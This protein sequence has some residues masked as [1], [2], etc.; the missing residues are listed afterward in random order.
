MFKISE[1][2]RLSGTSTRMLRHYE[3]WQLLIPNYIDEKTK[4]RFY[5]AQQLQTVNK[6]KKLQSLGFSLAL[7]KEIFAARDEQEIE[8]YLS[9]RKQEISKELEAIQLQQTSLN[10]VQEVIGTNAT[11][12]DYHVVLKEIPERDVM[13][14]RETIPDA[15]YEGELWRELY[16]EVQEQNVRFADPMLGISIYHDSEYQEESIDLEIQSSITGSYQETERVKY[17]VAPAL[18]V[19]SVTF[20]GPYEQMPNVMEI[21]AQWMENN[22]YRING[23]MLNINHVSPAQEENPDHWVTEACLVVAKEE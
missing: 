13:S 12:L 3:K 18:Q 20:H 1:F 11:I 6:I 4:Y 9:L 5:S 14:I 16:T 23:P 22:D 2:S 7:I 10:N 15:S 21:L 17:F 19:A 8:K